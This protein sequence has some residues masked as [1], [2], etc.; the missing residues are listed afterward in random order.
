MH[1]STND[2]EGRRA[3]A[4][5]GRERDRHKARGP[6]PETDHWDSQWEAFTTIADAW[7]GRQGE[8]S[9]NA[10]RMLS[11]QGAA[12]AQLHLFQDTMSCRLG[13]LNRR[14]WISVAG[15][16]PVDAG[17]LPDSR[18]VPPSIGE[19]TQTPVSLRSAASPCKQRVSA[20][21]RVCACACACGEVG[22]VGGACCS[23]GGSGSQADQRA[24][25]QVVGTPLCCAHL[26]R[27]RFESIQPKVN[28]SDAIRIM[29]NKVAN[30]G[31]PCCFCLES[32]WPPSP[33]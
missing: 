7:P 29:R 30:T 9:P 21:S 11:R 33:L 22:G 23:S 31:A 4:E 3:S 2:I 12:G 26:F 8:S 19:A 24:D 14:A 16:A 18:R 1:Q 6:R 32:D 10:P 28:Q 5:R 17:G 13:L 15:L 25:W 20:A 27:L